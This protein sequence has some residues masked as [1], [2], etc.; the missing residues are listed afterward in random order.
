[1]INP[2]K[3]NYFQN[4]TTPTAQPADARNQQAAVQPGGN[5]APGVAE[6]TKAPQIGPKECKT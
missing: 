5:A 2:V 3:F 6:A 4:Y 1:M